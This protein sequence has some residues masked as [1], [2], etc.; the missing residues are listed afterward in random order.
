MKPRK[1]EDLTGLKLNKWTIISFVERG[2]ND[3]IWRCKCDCGFEKNMTRS[4]FLNQTSKQCK[5]CYSKSMR[6][7]KK[8]FTQTAYGRIKYGAN[9]RNIEFNI[10]IE[11]CREL[12]IKQDKK[13]ALTRLPIS[14]SETSQGHNHGESTAS[15]D[16]IDNLKGYIEGNV[17]W[18]HKDVNRM[19]S[20]FSQE[21]FQYLCELIYKNRN[22]I[23]PR[24]FNYGQQI[25]TPSKSRVKLS[26]DDVI[27]IRLAYSKGEKGRDL[28]K[29]YNCTP[30]NI[31]CIVNN[32]SRKNT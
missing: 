32:Y 24:D 9:E 20:V 8:D 27:A 16:R 29:K 1:I 11:Y 12:Y 15:L 3:C 23:L 7:N 25:R 31:S 21:Y 2:K 18:I 13:C 28:A 10:S 14:F 26:D 4:N 6:N 17:Q 5:S 22:Y 30:G 19:K